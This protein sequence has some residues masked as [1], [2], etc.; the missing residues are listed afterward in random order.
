MTQILTNNYKIL[1]HKFTNLS[2]KYLPQNTKNNKITQNNK[3]IKSKPQ[4][5]KYI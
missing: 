2:Y 1:S 5:L 4:Q 3:S